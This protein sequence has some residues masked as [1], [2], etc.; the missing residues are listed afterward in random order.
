MA[1]RVLGAR[2][3][4]DAAGG[5][6]AL[7]VLRADMPA[8]ASRPSSLCVVLL[9]V[10]FGARAIYLAAVGPCLVART[11]HAKSPTSRSVDVDRWTL[12]RPLLVGA[13][14]GLAGSGALTALVVATL[15]SMGTRLSYLALFG[16]RI[17]PGD[18]RAVGPPGLADRANGSPSRGRAHVLAGRRLRLDRARPVLG[19]SVP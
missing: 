12:A 7:V 6:R 16:D 15:P 17:D 2:A 11:T 13:V 4:A 10:G 5:R 19:L 14:H 1:R 3:H 18:G 9:L 8:T